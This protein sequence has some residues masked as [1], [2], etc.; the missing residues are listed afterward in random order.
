MESKIE[1]LSIFLTQLYFLNFVHLVLARIQIVHISSGL[2][3]EHHNVSGR[4]I[5]SFM[6]SPNRYLR[7]F[8][9]QS[10]IFRNVG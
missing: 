3:N 8:S 5:H 4:I 6:D 1:K 9:R 10:D 2:K 7:N